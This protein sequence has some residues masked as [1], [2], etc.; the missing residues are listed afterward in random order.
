[1]VQL[2]HKSSRD[3]H[4]MLR[5]ARSSLRVSIYWRAG[6]GLWLRDLREQQGTLEGEGGGSGWGND[7]INL[8]GIKVGKPWWNARVSPVSTS[9]G[10]VLRSNTYKVKKTYLEK[11]KRPIVCSEE[12]S[13]YYV[14]NINCAYSNNKCYECRK[15]KMMHNSKPKGVRSY[16]V[17]FACSNLISCFILD[18]CFC[19]EAWFSDQN[20]C[21]LQTMNY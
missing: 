19:L 14:P 3:S 18:S 5:V 2:V 12:T 17:L 11:L 13:F 10:K 9:Q 6:R 20:H 16:L 7:G 4:L 15:Y 8:Q 1:M 21:R